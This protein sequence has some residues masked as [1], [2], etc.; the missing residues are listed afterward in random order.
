MDTCFDYHFK[1]NRLK[2]EKYIHDHDAEDEVAFT[3]LNIGR[4]RSTSA[5]WDCM[6]LISGEIYKSMYIKTKIISIQEDVE[7][8]L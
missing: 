1:A 7:I 2:P 6:E 8:E 3:F 5:K 4:L